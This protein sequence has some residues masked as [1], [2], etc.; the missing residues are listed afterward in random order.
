MDSTLS[1]Q[2][3]FG[4]SV[5]GSAA[6]PAPEVSRWHM[7]GKRNIRSLLKRPGAAT[8]PDG[9]PNFLSEFVY[10][11]AGVQSVFKP[12]RERASAQDFYRRQLARAYEDDDDDDD[13][14]DS[15]NDYD[16][17]LLPGWKVDRPPPL[18]LP[19]SPAVVKMGLP[20]V[21]V[22]LKVQARSYQGE[23]VPLVSLMS[24]LNGKAIVGHPVHIQMLE[25]GSTDLLLPGGADSADANADAVGPHGWR[26]ARR[27]VM[28]RVRRPNLLPLAA[29]M[30]EEV[31]LE[32]SHPA[33]RRRPGL[34]ERIHRKLARKR[35]LLAPKVRMLS[36]LAAERRRRHGG[37]SAAP[38]H[39]GRKRREA[40]A[41]LIKAGGEVPTVTCVPMKVVFSR[42][43]EAVGRLPPPAGMPRR[44][45]T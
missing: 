35:S 37:S 24:R 7:K 9:R 13:D 8:S 16:E 33:T 3:G 2:E 28:Q 25:D 10:E 36:S 26:T 15:D 19:L 5:S 40:L 12:G 29:P 41:Q 20:L 21:H 23:R 4:P 42:L 31:G 27:S 45:T 1:D 32:E 39:S 43:L 30:A 6:P 17:A 11:K 44:S 34:A 22:E 14:D 38:R 18:P